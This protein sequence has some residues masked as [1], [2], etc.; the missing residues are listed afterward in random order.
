MRFLRPGRWRSAALLGVIAAPL[1]AAC[2]ARQPP[3][4]A[5]QAAPPAARW[6]QDTLI[7]PNQ[8]LPN[9]LRPLRYFAW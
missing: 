4:N 8:L 9:G 6:T 1:L 3:A 2:A 7:Q 5:A